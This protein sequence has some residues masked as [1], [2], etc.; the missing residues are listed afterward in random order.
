[1]KKVSIL[2]YMPLEYYPPVTNFL[3]YL[4][5]SKLFKL[6]VYSTYNSKNRKEYDSK[7][8]TTIFRAKLPHKDD[9][10]LVRLANFFKYNINF[11]YKI[12]RE[13]PDVLI[14]YESISVLPAL[15]YLIFKSRNKV[16]LVIIH[17][18][19]FSK[20]WYRTTAPI[21]V[22]F[23]HFLEKLYLYDRADS[24][25]QTNPDR[26]SRFAQDNNIDLNKLF[27]ISICL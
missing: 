14:Y 23:N 25:S 6:S 10:V 12:F 7:R 11:T 21:V 19:Y 1:M 20:E 8:G 9:T 22:K 26:S 27:E 17:H 4:S 5:G 2:H 18:E 13:K 15:F 3:N 24:I 16:N